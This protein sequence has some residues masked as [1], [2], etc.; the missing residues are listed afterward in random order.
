MDIKKEM[1]LLE[2]RSTEGIKT[3][4]EATKPNNSN[5]PISGANI[6]QKG[7]KNNREKIKFP[8]WTKNDIAINRHYSRG[9]A[10]HD[11]L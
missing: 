2:Q 3:R 7:I 4:A 1:E 11:T 6:K 8:F 10:K 9:L 5:N